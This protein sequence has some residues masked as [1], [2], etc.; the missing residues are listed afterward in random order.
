MAVR[1]HTFA[2]GEYYHCYNR[3]T[4]K[5]VVFDDAQDYSYFIKSLEAYN[6]T[7][8]LGK[9]RLQD[10]STANQKIVEVV[11]Y[12][13]LPNH[14]H[15]ILKEIVQGGTSKLLQRV[16]I[17]YTLYYNQKNKRSGVLFQGVFKSKH[18]HNDQDL[19]Q[20]IAYVNYNNI[21][22]NITNT[23]LYRSFLNKKSQIVRDFDSNLIG[24]EKLIEIVE[25]IKLQRLSFIEA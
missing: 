20:V 18:I 8:V 14:F 16:G 24:K 12:C 23:S 22:H 1:N 7:T 19:R 13:L 3:G 9:L 10:K 21:I 4:D 6:S 15:L 2:V 11:S 17:G 5:R 25:I